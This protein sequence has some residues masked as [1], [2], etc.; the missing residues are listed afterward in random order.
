MTGLANWRKGNE[1][2]IERKKPNGLPT[3]T[4]DLD[5]VNEM[6]NCSVYTN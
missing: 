5:V 6:G 3:K 1:N 4:I 2:E